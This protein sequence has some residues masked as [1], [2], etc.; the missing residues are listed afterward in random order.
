MNERSQQ[1]S[2]STEPVTYQIPARMP[3]DGRMDRECVSLC[4]ALNALPGIQTFESCCGHGQRPFQVFFFGAKVQD[5][6]PVLR[7]LDH[8]WRVELS[9]VDCP[10]RVV[11]LLEG[12]P[13]PKAGDELAEYFHD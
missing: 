8:Q 13:D 9:H 10:Y 5:L 2:V 6:E 12:P 7:G 4:N 3:Y 1:D 11:F